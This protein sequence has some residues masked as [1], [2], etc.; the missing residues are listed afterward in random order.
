M[1]HSIQTITLLVHDYDEAIDFFT[2]ALRFTLVEDTPLG[3]GKRWV[4]VAPLGSS[5]ASLLLARADTPEQESHVGNQTGG[6]VLLF[7]HT[8][9]FWNDYHYMKACEVCFLE[10]PR[11]E[12]YGTVVVF[13]DLYGNKWDMVQPR[14]Q[15]N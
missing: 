12:P 8:N 2:K 1:T 5:G 11:E 9:D 15:D 7:L 6:R 4:I 3:K 14:E 10:E 13:K